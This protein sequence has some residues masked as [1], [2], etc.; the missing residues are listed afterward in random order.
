MS[1]G[2]RIHLNATCR[3]QVA[4]TSSKTGGFLNSLE[5]YIVY[6]EIP[7]FLKATQ[8]SSGLPSDFEGLSHGLKSVHRTFFASLCSADLFVAY[9][10]GNET[11]LDADVR[12]TSAATSSKTGGFLNLFES[13]IVYTEIP[14]FLKASQ[15]SSGLPSD[16]EGLSHG[17][18]SVHRT[19][20]AS[21]CSADLFVA[22]AIGNETHLNATCRWQVAATSSKTG[23]F[24]NSLESYIV[25]TEIPN[26]LKASQQSSGLP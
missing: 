1:D 3:W 12:W 25:H 22:Y 23:G 10:I 24:L 20:F 11:H 21:L 9:A 2:T 19:L 7:N 8:Q 18:K 6:T 13:Y 17:L 26:F 14:N 16:F 4:A 15:Q 5:S